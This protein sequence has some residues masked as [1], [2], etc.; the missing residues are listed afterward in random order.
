MA[1]QNTPAVVQ[2][3]V[4]DG[5]GRSGPF[6]ALDI[7]VL[8]DTGEI[9]PEVRVWRQG[10]RDWCELCCDPLLLASLSRMAGKFIDPPSVRGAV[11]MPSTGSHAVHQDDAST[12]V[13][14]TADTG[15]LPPHR[16]PAIPSQVGLRPVP[17]APRPLTAL[18]PVDAVLGPSLPPQR[19]GWLPSLRAMF[20]VAC[21]AFLVG[22]GYSALSHP[23]SD[24]AVA[25][26]GVGSVPAPLAKARITP[27]VPPAALAGQAAVTPVHIPVVTPR[28]NPPRTAEIAQTELRREIKRVAVDIRR[29]LSDPSAGVQ[30]ELVIEGESGRPTEVQILWPRLTAG[31]V[32]CIQQ[33]VRQLQVSPF[34]AAS[35]RLS[36]RFAW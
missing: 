11:A 27:P 1:E 14:D 29:C 9:L 2:W 6:S 34:G 4:A 36:R 13:F 20:I 25:G 17:A 8:L 7:A 32:T 15:R 30:L 24:R 22:V 19:A 10:M 18:P 16:P 23:R 3:F 28:P 21:I 26:P 31:T 5:G 12:A 33:S 35:Y